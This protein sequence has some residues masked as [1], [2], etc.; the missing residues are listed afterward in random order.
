MREFKAIVGDTPKDLAEQ[1]SRFG[2]R[3]DIVGFIAERGR[4][5]AFVEIRR[6]SKADPAAKDE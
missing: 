3:F 2:D 4:Y 6:R 1:L 5:V